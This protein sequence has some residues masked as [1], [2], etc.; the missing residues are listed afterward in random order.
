M[1]HWFEAV[2]RRVWVAPAVLTAALGFAGL[3]GCEGSSS[4]NNDIGLPTGRATQ[5]QVQQGRALVLSN[6]CADCHNRGVGN[7]ASANWLAGH[8]AGSNSSVFQIGPF[9]TYAANLTPDPT[10]GIGNFTD[11]QIYNA[12]KF[13]LD[14]GA[15]PEAV[16]SSTTPG[17]GSFP[18]T[19]HYLG[20]PMPWPAFRHHTDAELWAIVAYVKHGIKPVANTVPESQ[21]PPN[22]WASSYTD[23]AVGPADPPAYPTASEQ[24]VP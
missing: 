10:T 17:Q 19:P 24:F 1:N 22:F 16:I 11:R 14:P 6:G 4:S 8:M 9:T 18:A 13:G 12:L 2:K 3:A 20:P 23:N 7:P 15:T 5:E 21:S